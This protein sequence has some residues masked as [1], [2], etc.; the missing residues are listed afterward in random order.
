[1]NSGI[2]I[3]PFV[4]KRHFFTRAEKNKVNFGFFILILF[5]MQSI[6]NKIPPKLIEI[7]R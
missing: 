4:Q 2:A 3:L 5:T 1:M 6:R 7:L